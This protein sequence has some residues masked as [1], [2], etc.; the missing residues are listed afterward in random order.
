MDVVDA[1]AAQP[2]AAFNGTA[3]V[4]VADIT[5]TYALQTQ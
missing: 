4:P 2:T 1:I 5:I 3:D